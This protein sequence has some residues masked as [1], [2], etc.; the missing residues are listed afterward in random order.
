MA[1]KEKAQ[2]FAIKKALEYLDKDPETNLPKLV[3][4]LEAF[5]VRHTLKKEIDAVR[6]VADNPESNWYQAD[7]EPVDG[8]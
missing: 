6:A 1:F 7:P 4:W 8:H 5:D 2:I 3:D